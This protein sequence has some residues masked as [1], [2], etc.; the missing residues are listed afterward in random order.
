MTAGHA[1]ASM[2]NDVRL[3]EPVPIGATPTLHNPKHSEATGPPEP[4]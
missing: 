4:E 1:A 2:E 3:E